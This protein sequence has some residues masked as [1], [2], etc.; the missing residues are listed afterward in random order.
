[1]LRGA[2]MTEFQTAMNEAQAQIH[3]ANQRLVQANKSQTEIERQA[4][5][6]QLQQVQAAQ[7]EKL[8]RIAS[9]TEARIR[10]FEQLKKQ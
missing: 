5:L 4:A 8:S 6:K 2:G 9:Q 10:A 3:E 7:T 1:M